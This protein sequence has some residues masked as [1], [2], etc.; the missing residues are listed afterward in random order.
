MFIKSLKTIRTITLP[1]L[2]LAFMALTTGLSA[3]A[4]PE[5]NLLC[6]HQGPGDVFEIR[7]V[8]IG[9]GD[10]EV[11]L[12]L[13]STDQKVVRL[14][15]YAVVI[16]LT[17]GEGPHGVATEQWQ[18]LAGDQFSFTENALPNDYQSAWTFRLKKQ[19]VVYQCDLNLEMRA[20]PAVTRNN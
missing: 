7:T 9:D 4:Q 6:Y 16:E 5:L 10:R 18:V 12:R 15:K 3:H 19:P 17:P 11:A 13:S 8:L 1:A 14:K 2:L 20:N